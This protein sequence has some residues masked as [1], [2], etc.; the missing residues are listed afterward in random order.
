MCIRD[1]VGAD[2]NEAI[3]SAQNGD[4]LKLTADITEDI[5]VPEG[6]TVTIDLNGHKITAVKDH[7]ITNNGV[8]TVVRCV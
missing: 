7:T 2:L 1:R 5:T 4:T 3:A 8:L 6:K